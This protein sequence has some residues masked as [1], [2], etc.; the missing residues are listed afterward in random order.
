MGSDQIPRNAD[1]DEFYLSGFQIFITLSN[2][3]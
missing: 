3:S 1:N 2:L